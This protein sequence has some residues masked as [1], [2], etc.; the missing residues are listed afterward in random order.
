[1]WKVI[2]LLFKI[3]SA[4]ATNLQQTKGN[5]PATGTQEQHVIR[6]LQ[7]KAATKKRQREAESPDQHARRLER[8]REYQ[9][10][11]QRRKAAATTE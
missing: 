9:L 6:V 1:M 5:L 3:M 8:Q 4:K 10:A 7:E 11:Y 2:P